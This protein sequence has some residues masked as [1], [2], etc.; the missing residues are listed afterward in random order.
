LIQE[1]L[2]IYTFSR[3]RGVYQ[4]FPIDQPAV[5]DG[6]T[7]A[8]MLTL[9]LHSFKSSLQLKTSPNMIT[10]KTLKYT[11]IYKLHVCKTSCSKF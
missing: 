11:Y 4:L 5:Q 8:G 2:S 10:V 9:C 1:M 3:K 7:E 6:R